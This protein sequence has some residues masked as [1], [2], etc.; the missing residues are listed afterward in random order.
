MKFRFRNGLLV[1]LAAAVAVPA[2][3]GLFVG[4]TGSWKLA[5]HG[6]EVI[7]GKVT[8]MVV[9]PPDDWTRTTWGYIKNSEIWTLDGISLNEV[10]FAPDIATGKTLLVEY[11]KKDN[12]L[13]KFTDTMQLTELPEL[14]ERSWRVGRNAVVFNIGETSP[15]K[16]GGN[17][18]IRF[19]YEYVTDGNQ[20]SF[21]GVA[22]VA[23]VDKKL[24]L[25]VFEAPTLY[26]FDRDR[27][28]AVSLMDGVKFR[29]LP[30]PVR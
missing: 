26:Y 19:N 25:V 7:V 12:P 10:Y 28:K 20:L 5:K 30:P 8:T 1:A 18:A 14:L 24:E 9:T 21:K 4:A 17:D 3:A 15:A 13:P 16:L 29:T 27:A 11:N 23:I 6:E 2:S 22:T